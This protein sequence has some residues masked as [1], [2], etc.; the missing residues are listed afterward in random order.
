MAWKSATVWSPN[1][2]L[3]QYFSSVYCTLQTWIEL[4]N[5]LSQVAIWF[6]RRRDKGIQLFAI[7]LWAERSGLHQVNFLTDFLFNL[8]CEWSNGCSRCLILERYI[9]ILKLFFT[10][11]AKENTHPDYP[12][13]Q[14][15]G[16]TILQAC[17]K[18]PST[19]HKTKW[20]DVA[21]LQAF[22][23]GGNHQGL[24]Y[25]EIVHKT[26]MTLTSLKARLSSLI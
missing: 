26:G 12:E 21:L 22:K 6:K 1:N 8:F 19:R 17:A 13:T 4:L 10:S 2:C 16:W 24:S 23:V 7:Q 20:M 15:H 18:C 5:C 14:E 11:C 25:P 3:S 9:Y